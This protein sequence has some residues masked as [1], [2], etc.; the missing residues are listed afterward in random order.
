MQDQAQLSHVVQYL[1]EWISEE[2]GEPVLR[3]EG[4][5]RSSE[6]LD[7]ETFQR[8]VVNARSVAI[9]RPANLAK[10]A[11]AAVQD[12]SSLR[13]KQSFLLYFIVASSFL[14]AQ[15]CV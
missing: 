9:T 8:L 13:K 4:I 3:G 6:G 2:A 10:F 11:S 5:Q 14:F 7:V 15:T 1:Q 12:D